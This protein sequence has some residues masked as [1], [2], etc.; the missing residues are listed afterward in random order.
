[1]LFEMTEC[2][3][4]PTLAGLLVGLLAL[5]P[6]AHAD[7]FQTYDLAWSG[8]V[9]GN[10]ASA[11]G[12]I[13]FDLTALPNGG[14]AQYDLLGDVDS[15]TVTVTGASSGNGTWNQSELP[16]AGDNVGW[17]TGGG[18]LNR[19]AEVVG[20]STVDGG[21]WGTPDGD[22]GDFNLLYRDGGPLG[23]D[24]FTMTTNDGAGDEVLLTRFA[25]APEPTTLM[26]LATGLA[27]L[28]VV[29]R[30]QRC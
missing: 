19:L 25:P 26:L 29:A 20:Q 30:R 6:A 11:T 24:Y 5:V 28:A 10:G 21:P 15:L 1:M 4:I 9:F 17:W 12:Q 7:V 13:T 8:T 3:T 27:G 22:S 16:S 2:V 14:P 18:A 23:T